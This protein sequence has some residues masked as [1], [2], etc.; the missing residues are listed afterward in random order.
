MHTIIYALVRHT[1]T[2]LLMQNN[3]KLEG[4]DNPFRKDSMHKGGGVMLYVYR[5]R[6]S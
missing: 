5:Y 6:L 4:Y 3:W 2:T 1:L